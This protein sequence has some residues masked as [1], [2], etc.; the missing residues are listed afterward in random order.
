MSMPTY[1]YEC[2]SCG[3]VVEIFQSMTEPSRR[4][5]RKSDPKAC[6]CNQPVRRRIGTG[7]GVIFKGSGFYVTD[8]RSESYKKAAKAETEGGEKKS[9]K[10]EESGK[11]Q[12]KNADASESKPAPV[13]KAKGPV[14]SDAKA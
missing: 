3:A 13:T 5:L 8:Y 14:A 9:P 4:K 10:S 7:A 1:E 6:D 11:S 2:T 12:K